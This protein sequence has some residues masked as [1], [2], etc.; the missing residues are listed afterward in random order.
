MQ[1]NTVIL[2]INILIILI[3]SDIMLYYYNI[4]LIVSLLKSWLNP[5]RPPLAPPLCL[6]IT[7]GY[8]QCPHTASV[9]PESY[10]PILFLELYLKSLGT[11]AAVKTRFEMGN[12][13][14]DSHLHLCYFLWYLP[15]YLTSLSL[16]LLLIYE[17]VTVM[18]TAEL[19]KTDSDYST[20]VSVIC[21]FCDNPKLPPWLNS[22]MQGTC[23]HSSLSSLI[24]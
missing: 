4:V 16:R 8:T 12:I 17:T 19:A 24:I 23:L 15:T 18:S 5:T 10:G 3:A 21:S 14:L 6:V 20:T 9:P 13:N 22:P 2:I 1:S 7:V 11:P